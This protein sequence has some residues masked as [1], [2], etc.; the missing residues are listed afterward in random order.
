MRMLLLAVVLASAATQAPIRDHGGARCMGAMAAM[1]IIV[2]AQEK[3]TPPG[4][5]CQ[6]PVEKMR[7]EAVACA[8]HAHN[9][10]KDLSDPAYLSAHTDSQCENFCH[11]QKC[12]CAA[13]DCP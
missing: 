1:Q 7:K 6:R 12:E 13:M 8:C 2:A 5:W 3:E 4:T 10:D 11:T 9:C